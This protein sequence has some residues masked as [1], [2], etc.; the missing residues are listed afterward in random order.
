ML[1][2]QQNSIY[3]VVYHVV[4]GIHVVARGTTQWLCRGVLC[5]WNVKYG[6]LVITILFTVSAVTI[7]QEKRASSFSVALRA[8]TAVIEDE[9]KKYKK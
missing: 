5:H 8:Y 6:I 2:A 9:V 4:Y 1:V 3:Y 7:I